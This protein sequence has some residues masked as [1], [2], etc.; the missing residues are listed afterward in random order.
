MGSLGYACRPGA[1]P[2]GPLRREGCA[3]PCARP[4]ARAR[5]AAATVRGPAARPRSAAALPRPATN[6]LDTLACPWWRARWIRVQGQPRFPGPCG[7][8]P[9]TALSPSRAPASPLQPQIKA[10]LRQ[11][12]SCRP[13]AARAEGLRRARRCGPCCGKVALARPS[14]VGIE[15]GSGGR[16]CAQHRSQ[17]GRESWTASPGR[18]R[19]VGV[20]TRRDCVAWS[21]TPGHILRG[22]S[23]LWLLVIWARCDASRPRMAPH[24][25]V[26]MIRQPA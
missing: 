17:G 8:G 16:R 21:R 19:G 13:V 6:K 14:Y 2:S 20:R 18:R 11:F 1:C 9:R 7:K 22:G 23:S 24:S 5:A 10:L 12:S 25:A 15:Q 4:R 26:E 3:A